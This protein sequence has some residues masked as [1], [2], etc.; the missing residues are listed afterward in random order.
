MA[1]LGVWEFR[2]IQEGKREKFSITVRP[3][4]CGGETKVCLKMEEDI[5][6]M[7]RCIVKDIFI[8]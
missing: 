8:L 2:D 1:I 7:F 3:R 6:W 4:C 5:G